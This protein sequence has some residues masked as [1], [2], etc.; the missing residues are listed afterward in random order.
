M[1]MLLC[2]RVP[3]APRAQVRRLA[4]D[5]PEVVPY[6]PLP[7]LTSPYRYVVWPRID[8]KS[9]LKAVAAAGCI[10]IVVE[11]LLEGDELRT[12]VRAAVLQSLARPLQPR[13][14]V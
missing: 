12:D 6:I 14:L 3:H 2:M 11:S 4:A 10:P 13:A 5:R 9:C 7:P 1:C 8:Q